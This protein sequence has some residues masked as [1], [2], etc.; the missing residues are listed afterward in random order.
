M[1]RQAQVI[2]FFFLEEKIDEVIVIT[3]NLIS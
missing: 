1:N 3:I 2:F